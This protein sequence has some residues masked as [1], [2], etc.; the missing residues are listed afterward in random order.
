MENSRIIIPY[1]LEANS[2]KLKIIPSNIKYGIIEL[3]NETR[4]FFPGY[5]KQF[6]LQTDIRLFV[7][8]LSGSEKGTEIGSV[9]GGYLSHP[10]PR[11]IKEKFFRQIPDC[12]HH[13]K[14]SF[15]RWYDE[16]PE[17]ESEHYIRIYKLEE[18]LFRLETISPEQNS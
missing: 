5:R 15:K 1:E 9:Y 18:E 4:E 12:R 16:H 10:R 11:D 13:I 14:G 7:M 2:V 17:I 8:H 3:N 6:I